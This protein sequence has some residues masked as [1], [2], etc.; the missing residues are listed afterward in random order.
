[1]RPCGKAGEL[2]AAFSRVTAEAFKDARLVSCPTLSKSPEQG[3]ILR[4]F[5]SGAP[6]CL[7]GAALFV[8]A[9]ARY[10]A[11]NGLHFLFMLCTVLYLRLLR[12]PRG[13]PACPAP[14]RSGGPDVEAEE[15]TLIVIDTFAVL[16]GIAVE[17]IWRELYL[18][19]LEET[20]RDRGHEVFVLARLYGSRNPLLLWKALRVMARKPGL[21]LE[22]S[23]LRPADFARLALHVLLY[24]FALVR[25]IRSLENFPND[26]P[27]RHIREALIRGAGQCVL[28]GESRR[29]AARALCRELAA[30]PRKARV[31]SWYENQTVNKAFQ[32]GLT[33]AKA[34]GLPHVPVTGAQLFIWPDSLLNNH[35]D[36][37]EAAL[38]LAPD[39][40]LV[41]GPHFLPE[42]S[43]QNYSVGP[44]LRYGELFSVSPRQAA[45]RAGDPTLVLLS[46]HP[47]ET[48]RVLDLLLPLAQENPRAFI[49]RFHPAARPE[50]YAS[51]L[52]KAPRLSGGPLYEAL[53]AAGAAIGSGSGSL[54]EAVVLG[55]PVLV[56]ED[57]SGVPGLGLNYL[58]EYGRGTLWAGVRDRV[59]IEEALN[60]LRAGLAN[61]ERPEMV[62]RFRDLLFCEPGPERIRADFDLS[63]TNY[64]DSE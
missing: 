25:L 16:P 17:G 9:A 31:I 7:P 21:L 63:T 3:D 49:Y 58:P 35:P 57:A 54:A 39:R 22:A 64:S 41:N 23:L 60:R 50:H 30:L 15:K 32:L 44:S 12:L 24:P 34:L 19:G 33:E 5:L 6:A 53:D 55:V 51:L 46:Y 18:K 20:A 61:P 43:V 28:I 56:V 47:E 36:D 59:Q 1:M 8:R 62:R 48:K 37:A 14:A 42:D 10:L 40:V 38:G 26:A 45:D 11:A 4:R 52:P 29:L 27:E 2:F 13:L